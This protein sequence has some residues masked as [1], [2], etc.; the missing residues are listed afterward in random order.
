MTELLDPILAGDTLSVLVAVPGY[1]ASEGWT[2]TYSLRGAGRIDLVAVAE[3]DD[4]RLQATAAVTAAWLP[5]QYAYT[6]TVAKDDDRYTVA[7]GAT[8]V[9]ADLTQAQEGYDPRTVAEKALA[10]AEAALAAYN[11]SRGM[12]KKY[13]IGARSMEFNTSSEILEVISYWR[14]RVA[15]EQTRASIA[16]GLGNPR[17]LKVRF[18]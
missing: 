1:P 15:N 9:T 3:G 14:L 2:L 11:A 5:G 10:D 17:N 16:Q 6:A 4:Y 12:V 13:S 18:V 8:T 7:T